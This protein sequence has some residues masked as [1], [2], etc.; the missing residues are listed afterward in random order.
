MN[1]N[2]KGNNKG[3]KAIPSHT[4]LKTENN[5][6]NEVKIKNHKTLKRTKI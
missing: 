6:G 5:K 1:G 4:Y 2:N 3:I